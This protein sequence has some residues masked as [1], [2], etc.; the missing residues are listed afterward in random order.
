MTKSY[1][2]RPKDEYHCKRPRLP[3]R[4]FAGDP[5]ENRTRVTAVKVGALKKQS[6]VAA[7][8]KQSG[9]LFLAANDAAVPRRVRLGTRICDSRQG[10]MTVLYN[11]IPPSAV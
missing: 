11:D 8:R 9:G 7:L 10:V 4:S 3:T 1:I 5:D 2:T 6:C